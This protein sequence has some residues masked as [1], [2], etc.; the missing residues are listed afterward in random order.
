MTLLAIIA[1]DNTD[2]QAILL[3]NK[4]GID[5]LQSQEPE[6]LS[7]YQ[8]VLILDAEKLSMLQCT[9]DNIGAV[10]VDFVSGA[11][12]HRRKFGGGKSQMLAKAIGLNKFKSP[13][14]LD[15]TAGLGRDAFVLACLGCKVDMVELSPIIFELLKDGL[16]RANQDLSIS[17]ITHDISLTNADSCQYIASLVTKPDV[18]Y[19]DPMFPKRDKSALVKKEM[20]IFKEILGDDKDADKLLEVSLTIAKKRVVVKR[21]RKSPFL[22]DKKPS[23]IMEGKANRFDVYVV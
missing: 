2:A 19:L 3:A 17:Q 20:R 7:K 16:H 6:Q 5:F 14:V 11:A 21:P 13:H 12:N 8:G 23:F 10:Y 15:A 22:N 1:K 18:I 9:K 4:L